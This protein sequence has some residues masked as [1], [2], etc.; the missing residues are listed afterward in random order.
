M[1]PEAKKAS[2]EA[3]PANMHEARGGKSKQGSATREYA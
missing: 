1:K 2:K 3:L